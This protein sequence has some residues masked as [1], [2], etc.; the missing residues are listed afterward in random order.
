[1]FLLLAET[2]PEGLG[3]FQGPPCLTAMDEP[4]HCTRLDGQGGAAWRP[5]YPRPLRNLPEAEFNPIEGK[6]SWNLGIVKME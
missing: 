3:S 4:M 5:I 1:M 6:T 2:V